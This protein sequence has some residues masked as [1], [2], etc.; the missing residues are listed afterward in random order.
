MQTFICEKIPT[1]EDGYMFISARL[2]YALR[3][4][5]VLPPPPGD[6]STA[7][8]LADDL[9]VSETYLRT[10]LNELR[11][12]GLLVHERGPRGGY[13]LARPT[14]DI[15]I[16]AV[17][18]ALR[19]PAV[20][21]HPTPRGTDKFGRSLST[22]WKHVE[23]STVNLLNSITVADVADGNGCATCHDATIV[24]EPT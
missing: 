7:T 17:L 16:G 2:D 5:A 10:T 4:L 20:E 1:C 23:D 24:H 8:H 13:R 19:I 15:T 11:A 18:A 12:G 22:L 6:P 21:V 9:E 3:A 14:S